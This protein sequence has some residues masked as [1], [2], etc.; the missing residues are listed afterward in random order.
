MEVR[1]ILPWD[2]PHFSRLVQQFYALP[3]VAQPI[4]EAH[5]ERTF[6]QLMGDTP[7][8]RCFVAADARDI[9]HGYCLCAIT[10]SNEAGGLCVWIDEIM[11]EEGLRG[12]G[13]GHKLVSAARAA[14]PDA[15]RFRLEVTDENPGA[16]ALY[17]AL[18]FTPLPYRQM[19][20]DRT[21]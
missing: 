10:W 18:G 17:A 1:E 13:I 9:P 14:Y 12:Q 16:A 20:L 2:Q 7:Y 15:A 8:L 4:P 21:D 6:Q 19:A 3:A 5:A 11:I